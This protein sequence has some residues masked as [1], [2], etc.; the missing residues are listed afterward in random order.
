MKDGTMMIAHSISRD[1]ESM[2]T[3]QYNQTAPRL[4]LFQMLEDEAAMTKS[5]QRSIIRQPN[6]VWRNRVVQWFYDI[7]DHFGDSRSIVYTAVYILDC[8]YSGKQ[9]FDNQSYQRAALSALFLAFRVNGSSSVNLND[10]ISMSHIAGEVKDFVSMGKDILKNV[11][12]SKRSQSPHN[13]V[14]AYVNVLTHAKFDASDCD[15]ILDE[16][17]YYCDLSVSDFELSHIRSSELAM[18]AIVNAVQ[19]KP[20]DRPNFRLG[21]D[22]FMKKTK[23][24]TKSDSFRRTCFRLRSIC[25]ELHEDQ[26]STRNAGVAVI[27]GQCNDPLMFA[28]IPSVKPTLVHVISVDEIDS[29][30]TRPGT[31]RKLPTNEYITNSKSRRID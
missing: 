7:V 29:L 24:M 18:A 19:A 25:K 26:V 28:Q 12:L 16:A 5:K 14:R 23:G 27:E 6:D 2:P 22:G 15:V 8:Y 20:S 10:L 1:D 9:Y 31:K 30:L 21:F 17:L 3:E 4:T 13:F 11:N